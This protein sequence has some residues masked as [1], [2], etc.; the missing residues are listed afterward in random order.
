M[1]GFKRGA[2][3]RYSSV[4]RDGYIGI[5]PGAGSHL[6]DGFVL[7]TFDLDSWIQRNAQ[8]APGDRPAHAVRR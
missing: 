7:N 5:G 1:W 8:W 4:T 3:P 6:P 2:V